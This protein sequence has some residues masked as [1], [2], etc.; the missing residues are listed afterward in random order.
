VKIEID[1]IFC[2][3]TNANKSSIDILEKSLSTFAPGYQYSYQYK[4]KF[5]NGRV[6]LFSDSTFLTG[7]LPTVLNLVKE[8]VT[9]VDNRS[10]PTISMSVPTVPLRDYQWDAINNAVSNTLNNTWWPRGVI[11][12]PTGG[13]KTACAAGIIQ[14]VNKPTLFIVNT[15]DLLWQAHR[16][17]TNYGIQ[18]GV[19][20]DGKYEIQNTTVA[21]VQS[22]YSLLNNNPI[23]LRFLRTIEQVFFDEA[24]LVAATLEKG[25]IFLKAAAL[26]PS[27]Y[28]R[29]GLS[30]TPYMKDQYSNWLLEGVTGK[31]VYEIKNKELIDKGYL[32]EGRVVMF[33]I[34]QDNYIANSW[35]NCYD[36]GVVAY[37]KRNNKIV[38]LIAS[39]SK[40]VLVLVQREGH[41]TLLSNMCNQKGLN[42][43]FIFGNHSSKERIQAIKDLR[44]GK[45]DG[46][47]AS[48]I[49]DQG[50]DIQEIKTLI[51]AGGGK[52]PVRNL[53][54]L[55]RGL[56]ISEGK[57]HLEAYDF[58]DNSTRW[59]RNHSNERKKLWTSEGF[60][61]SIKEL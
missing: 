16:V 47:I 14:M 56:R 40:P 29:W 18:T 27:A 43:P 4:R 10:L 44:S 35:P 7:L 20:G 53:Q 11:K 58:Y 41:G 55:G 13:G 24:H 25:N 28:M 31:I 5:W 21:T 33:N 36:E 15:K 59:L 32:S 26:I 17:F 45:I 38:E 42:V 39:K 6:S 37:P 22:I 61:I 23:K 19:I 57:S 52:S 8:P 50:V 1:N 49:W 54:R 9:L 30:A 34:P 46:V 12:I 2:T 3:V 51:L 48:T 60:D